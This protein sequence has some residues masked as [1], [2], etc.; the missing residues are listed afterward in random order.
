MFNEFYLS[1]IDYIQTL[2]LHPILKGIE[3]GFFIILWQI[4]GVPV[5]SFVR[6]LTEPIKT[7][8]NMKVNYFVLIF[9]CLMGFFTSVYFLYGLDDENVYDRSFRLIG[10]FGSV[11]LFLVPILLILGVGII[12]PIYSITM[13]VVNFVVGILPILAGI[14]VLMPI[15]FVGGFLSLVGAVVGRL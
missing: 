10:I 13:A 8:Y 7:R 9:G 15:L 3:L 11:C 12:V 6:N 4:V 2:M 14:A 1:L 5:M